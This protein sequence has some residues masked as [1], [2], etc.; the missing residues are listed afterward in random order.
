MMLAAQ[1]QFL[2]RPCRHHH[3]RNRNH[4][5]III[6]IICWSEKRLKNKA[7]ANHSVSRRE[8]PVVRCPV[9]HWWYEERHLARKKNCGVG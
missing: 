2:V 3:H 7:D 4:H 9:N 6:I 5:L 1:R 8:K